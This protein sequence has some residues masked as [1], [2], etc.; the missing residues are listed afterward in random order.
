MSEETFSIEIPS[1]DEGF[2]GV[3]CPHC[4]ERFKLRVDE[5]QEEEPG[6]L[7]CSLCGMTADASAFLARDDV[8]EV[9]QAQ[10]VNLVREHLDKTLKK[11]ERDTRGSKH[12]QFKRD[13]KSTRKE[14]VPKLREFT[15]GAVANLPCCDRHVKVDPSAASSVLYCPYCS[16][17]VA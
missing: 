16:Q 4:D 14:P 1:D 9:A 10:A 6:T 13:R 17:V 3:Q 11:L 12:F 5:Y 2:V 7:T 15:D 8:R